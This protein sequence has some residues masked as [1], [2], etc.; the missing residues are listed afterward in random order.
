MTMRRTIMPHPLD[1]GDEAG[2]PADDISR[3]A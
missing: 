3:F 1:E 2:A